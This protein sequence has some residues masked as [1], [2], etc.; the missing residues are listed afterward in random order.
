VNS[1]VISIDQIRSEAAAA[2]QQYSDVNAACPYPFDTEAGR[3]FRQEFVAMRAALG[4]AS[5]LEP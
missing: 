5:E 1:P 3:L 2:A 4:A